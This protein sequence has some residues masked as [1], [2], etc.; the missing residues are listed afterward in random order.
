MYTVN[1]KPVLLFNNLTFKASLKSSTKYIFHMD[2]SLC[3]TIMPVCCVCLFHCT[4][5]WQCRCFLLLFCSSVVLGF[6]NATYFCALYLTLYPTL[7]YQHRWVNCSHTQEF[8]GAIP[9]T[10][11]KAGTHLALVKVPEP[12]SPGAVPAGGTCT[13]SPGPVKLPHSSCG[14]NGPI[15]FNPRTFK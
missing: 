3:E 10:N 4:F 15:V 7:L 8:F 14:G 9:S 12:C 1:Q 11:P 5:F 13:N 2:P 6:K